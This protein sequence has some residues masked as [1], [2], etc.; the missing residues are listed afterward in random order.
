MSIDEQ[1]FRSTARRVTHLKATKHYATDIT[2]PGAD[3][4][5]QWKEQQ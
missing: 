1:Q 4:T 5:I 3:I 2:P